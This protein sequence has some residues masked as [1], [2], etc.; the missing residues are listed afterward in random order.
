MPAGHISTGLDDAEH[1]GLDR[2]GSTTPGARG[3]LVARRASRGAASVCSS[4]PLVI[5]DAARTA[6][7]TRCHRT[8][9]TSSNAT[10]P[11][12][13]HDREAAN[14]EREHGIR[15]RRR[16]RTAAK[17]DAL[18]FGLRE[19]LRDVVEDADDGLSRSLDRHELDPGADPQERCERDQELH[20]R[21]EPQPVP[22]V[23]P[24]A[25][26]RE[27]EQG[28]ARREHRRLPQMIRDRF[29]HDALLHFSTFSTSSTFQLEQQL[30]RLFDVVER[31]IA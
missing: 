7:D 4:G 13:P 28:D 1:A 5:A 8:A 20:R 10:E 9:Q 26:E 16:D 21:R 27:G 31:Q 15:W 2:P 24:V 22:D 12:W 30:L 23:S 11:S 19:R 6:R 18:G 17:I 3:S 29:H 14:G 25:S